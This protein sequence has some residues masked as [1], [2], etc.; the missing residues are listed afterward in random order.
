MVFLETMAIWCSSCRAQQV[1]ATAAWSDIDTDRVAWVAL[2]VEASETADALARYRDQHG[3]PFTYA[4]ADRDVSRALAADFG[5]VVLSPPSVN[6]IVIGLDGRVT[7]SRGHL[8]SA[9][10]HALAADHGA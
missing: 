4:I 2:D 6:V 9:E 8:S 3:F 5:D 1:E 7:H 10:I